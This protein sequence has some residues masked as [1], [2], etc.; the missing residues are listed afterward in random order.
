MQPQQKVLSQEDA[1][2]NLYLLWA[3]TEEITNDIVWVYEDSAL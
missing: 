1:M 3:T 2:I